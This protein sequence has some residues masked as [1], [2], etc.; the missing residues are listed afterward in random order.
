[1]TKILRPGSYKFRRVFFY[2]YCKTTRKQ[3][4]MASFGEFFS[5]MA[6]HDE[7]GTPYM[8]IS[9]EERARALIDQGCIS[10]K[11]PW[12]QVPS[13]P[14]DFNGTYDHS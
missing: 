10:Q 7:G 5:T 2:Y 6:L 4:E 1:M 14:I 11:Q 8:G 9:P 12:S 13:L 3:H